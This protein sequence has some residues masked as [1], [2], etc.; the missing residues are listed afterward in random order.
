MAEASQLTQATF[1]GINWML[2]ALCVLAFLTR[3]YIRWI[4]FRRLFVEDYLMITAVAILTGIEAMSQYFSDDI[5]NLMAWV[6]KTYDPTNFFAFAADTEDMLKAC[7]SGIILFIAGFYIIKVN[8]L[9]FFYRMGNRL[10]RIYR[11]IW[12]SVYFYPVLSAWPARQDEKM[13]AAAPVCP[14]GLMEAIG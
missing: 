13:R 11:I 12:W 4:C 10:L 5:Y 2:Y 8:F 7:G 14:A 9:L 3:L 1:L 6:N